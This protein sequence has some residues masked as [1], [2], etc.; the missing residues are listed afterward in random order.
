MKS[1]EYLRYRRSWGRR[2]FLRSLTSK[3]LPQCL[4]GVTEPWRWGLRPGCLLMRSCWNRTARMSISASI[5]PGDTSLHTY[6]KRIKIITII[7]FH[8][9][10]TTF[11]VVFKIKNSSRSFVISYRYAL[12][13]QQMLTVTKRYELQWNRLWAIALH[14]AT[15][16]SIFNDTCQLFHI[17]HLRYIKSKSIYIQEGLYRTRHTK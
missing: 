2:R 14:A 10:N 17:C 1:S 4:F 16:A 8:A 7:G 11:T 9:R 13:H 5:A 12:L 15:A 6:N 3:L